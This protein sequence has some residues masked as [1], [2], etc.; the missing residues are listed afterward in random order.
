MK[1]N[2]SIKVN[3]QLL[4]LDQ[5]RIMGIINTTPDSFSDGGQFQ[6][7][8]KAFLHAA[9]MV[10]E[11]VDII[12]VG[13]YS[14]RPGANYIS[15]Q[16]EI[17]RTIPLIERLSKN[18][19]LPISIDTFRSV[20]AQQAIES[21]AHIINDISAGD[22]DEHM[23]ST[24]ASLGVPYIAMHKQ[25]LP[26][27]MQDNPSYNDV[28]NDVLTYLA[29]KKDQLITAG[30][31]DIIV[32]P[33]FGFGKTLNQNYELLQKMHN[34]KLLDLPILVGISRKSM[35]YK[36]LEIEPSETSVG[37]AFIHSISLQNGANILRVHDVKEAKQCVQIWMQLAN[38]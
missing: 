2:Y 36:L 25:G 6:N 21:G 26:S 8:D 27:N 4:S 14:S 37:N 9:K 23:I 3:G 15:I 20:V 38:C 13:G 28:T 24:V 1:P 33:G 19:D 31:M 5:P 22:D 12:D 17:D 35:I 29:K 11:G 7:L 34:L 30:I 10:S 16:E 18:F 32:D